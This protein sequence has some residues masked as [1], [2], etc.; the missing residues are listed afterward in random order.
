M[1]VVRVHTYTVDPADVS[2][3]IAKR[4]DLIAGIRVEHPGLVETRL[5]RLEDGSFIDSWR[6]A[7]PNQMAA[8]APVASSPTAAAVMAL[9]KDGTAV[10]G[11]ILDETTAP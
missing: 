5:I 7:S 11:E 10:N 9:T 8:A 3:L 6:W 2:E 4:A 1:A